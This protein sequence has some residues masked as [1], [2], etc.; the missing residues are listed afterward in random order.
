VLDAL[1][2]EAA[3]RATL[4][5]EGHLVARG[6]L[7]AVRLRTQ[8][9]DPVVRILK[10]PK[11]WTWLVFSPCSPH[12]LEPAQAT[13]WARV[14]SKLH[15]VRFVQWN[16]TEGEL[17]FTV[18]PLRASVVRGHPV[19]VPGVPHVEAQVQLPA[20][21]LMLDLSRWAGVPESELAAALV[22]AYYVEQVAVA[23]PGAFTNV[24]VLALAGTTP[25]VIEVKRRSRSEEQQQLP[26]TMTTTQTQTLGQ[27]REA[28]C[29]VHI[30]LLIV[31]PG[32]RR[33]P[34]QWLIHG[35]WRAGAAVI[36]LGWG[37]AVL[38]ILGVIS[39]P[40]LEALRAARQAAVAL[41]TG[42]LPPASPPRAS[43]AAL[44]RSSPALLPGWHDLPPTVEEPSAHRKSGWQTPKLKGARRLTSF[45]LEYAFL[46]VWAPAS[47]R[48]RG[49]EYASAATAFLAA[50]TLDEGARRRLAEVTEP[51]AVLRIARRAPERNDWLTL[52]GTVTREV[53]RFAYRRER[54]VHLIGTLPLLLDDP[55][56]ALYDPVLVG[57]QGRSGLQAL[58]LLRGQLAALSAREAGDCCFSCVHALPG[59]WPGFVG[60]GHPEG[61]S[62]TLQCVGK[63][64]CGGQ[65]AQGEGAIIPVITKGGPDFQR[66]ED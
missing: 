36:R 19:L 53:L 66:K 57:L 9:Q 44:P 11:D 40:T 8:R 22:E 14:I 42:S 25:V 27:L 10:R 3:V 33:Q 1:V 32:L 17:T 47:I 38:D 56:T 18:W 45:T 48:M 28:G 62:G 34:G 23:D 24:D 58:N 16:E 51:A 59:A 65:H 60:C 15:G 7:W 41:R 31:P 43:S 50:R 4:R 61:V 21:P 29:E 30:A 2:S 20:G 13:L 52:R 54:A 63:A 37:E 6:G 39:A 35:H 5:A 46:S 12:E 49:L 64:A 55:E 26:L